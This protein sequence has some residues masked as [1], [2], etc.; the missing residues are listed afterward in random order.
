MP[1]VDGK[2]YPYTPEGRAAA[3]E[4]MDAKRQRMR[5]GGEVKRETESNSIDDAFKKMDKPASE[6]GTG[7]TFTAAAT[8]AGFANTKA[9]RTE[10]ANNVLADDNATAK[11]KRKANFYRNFIA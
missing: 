1:L 3:R 6:G 7:G 10:F 2:N 8:K 11:M 9:G 4:A 5:D